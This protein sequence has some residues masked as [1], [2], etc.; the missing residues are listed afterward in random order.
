MVYSPL[1][2][3]AYNTHQ[4]SSR[5]GVR[6]DRFI[7]HHAV[8][9]NWRDVLAM[10]MGGKEVSANYIIGNGGEIISV[11]P[12]ED[13]A[14]TS[15][16]AAWDGRA[17]TVEVCNETLAPSYTISAAAQESLA[18]LK[19]DVS[20]RYGFPLTRSGSSSTVIGHREL[21]LWYG[22]SYATACPGG[23]PIDQ[24]V[25]RANQIKSGE[26]TPVIDYDLL[27]RQKE[28]TMYVQGYG[29]TSVYAVSTTANNQP[30]MRVVGESEAAFAR[31]GGLVIV[32]QDKTNGTLLGL[33]AESGY[34]VDI[35][36]T[37]VTPTVSLAP[38]E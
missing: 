21:Y 22:A 6:I 4:K 14:W 31:A 34:K 29:N 32:S 20:M 12:E 26:N 37:P 15:S 9:R 36:R 18:R 38:K 8:S 24:N 28:D 5:N 35:G 33:S 27:R 2:N 10:M 3:I 16:S 13:R 23:L 25:V 17:I 1:T 11:V 30:M 7:D 19:A